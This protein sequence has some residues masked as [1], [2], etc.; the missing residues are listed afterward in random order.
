M[1]VF[2]R[3]SRR[4]DAR[5]EAKSQRN[6]EVAVSICALFEFDSSSVDYNNLVLYRAFPEK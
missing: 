2:N 1:E 4:R 3:L 6:Q 5:Y